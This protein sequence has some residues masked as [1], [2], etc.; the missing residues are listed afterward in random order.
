VDTPARKELKFIHITKTAG[1]S[2]EDAAMVQ[3]IR[4]GRYHTEYGDYHNYFPMKPKALQDRYDWFLVVRNPYD[5][6]LS[7]YHCMYGGVGY[8]NPPVNHTKQQMSE[9]LIYKIMDRDKL[10]DHYALQS[11]YI[12][13]DTT[14]RIHILRFENIVEDFRALME[15]YKLPLDISQTKSNIPRQKLFTV[16]DFSPDLVYL[17]NQVYADDFRQFGYH[18]IEIN[19]M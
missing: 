16:D 7:E 9:F 4:F 13:P 17:I 3:G 8:M 18:M 12:S 14:A 19:L 15:L 5:R 2:I 1:T 11:K 10:G 6:I